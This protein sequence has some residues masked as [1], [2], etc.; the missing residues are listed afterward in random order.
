LRPNAEVDYG[1]Y[2]RLLGFQID[3]G[4]HGILADGA[5]SE[6][7]LLTVEERKHLIGLRPGDIIPAGTPVG[8]G[9][10]FD[11][12]KYLVAGEVVEVEVPGIGTRR[13]RVINEEI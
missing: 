9:A 10:R 5:T 3:N 6:P 1:T 8:V 12:P 13:K 4:R 2:E 11:P 7:A